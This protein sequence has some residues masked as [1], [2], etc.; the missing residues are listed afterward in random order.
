MSKPMMRRNTILVTALVLLPLVSGCHLHSPFREELAK[1]IQ[2]RY[3][4]VSPSALQALEVLDDDMNKLLDSQQADFEVYRETSEQVLLNMKWNAY[5]TAVKG[6]E[7]SYFRANGDELG[8]VAQVR[9]GIKTEEKAIK[10]LNVAIDQLDKV[11]NSLNLALKKAEA[12]TSLA[13]D[14]EETKKTI[15]AALTAIHVAVQQNP[16][17]PLAKRLSSSVGEIDKYI[18]QLSDNEMKKENK[19]RVFSLVVEAMRLGRDI[20]A[21]EKEA[22]E[23][24]QTYHERLLALY[25]AEK[26][27]L[28]NKKEL[29]NMRAR[30][31]DPE[32]PNFP[33]AQRFPNDEMIRERLNILARQ[34]SQD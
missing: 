3:K 5:R 4:L 10:D 16:D 17:S 29:Q 13:E 32:F 24:D 9:D 33:D 23:Q 27:I 30:Y 20:A 6:L 7:D 8:V 18:K 19:K 25:K 21:L 15:T 2:S 11:L 1:D 12:H 22:V 34:I 31:G 14:L 26:K 28:P